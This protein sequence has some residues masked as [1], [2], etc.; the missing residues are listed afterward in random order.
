MA[1]GLDWRSDGPGWPHHERSRFVAA[2]G[3]RW[4]VQH[5]PPP[6]PQAPTWLL[7]HGTGAS[8]HSWRGLAPLL[9]AHVGLVVPDLPGHGFSAPAPAGRAGIAPVA[10]ALRALMRT[11][12]VAPQLI[13]GHSAGAAIAVRMQ[14]QEADAAPAAQRLAGTH[15]AQRVVGT[16]AA[17][18]VVGI[19][20]AL[21]PLR[22]LAGL[23]FP[24]AARLL[25]ANPLVP[26]FFA[27]RAADRAVLARLLHGTGSTLD[28][29]GSALYGRLIESPAHVAGALA[30]MAQWD[31]PALARDLPRL[32]T[33]LHLLVA[34][35]DGTVPPDDAGRVRA[36][37]PTVDVQRLAG[38]GHLAHEEDPGSIAA[39]LLALG[40]APAT[41]P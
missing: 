16:H 19:N 4:H 32:R 18:R 28:A 10:A 38:L 14:L 3:Q 6:Q 25:A 27:W 2:D 35:L 11:L 1:R 9:A 13:V 7:L 34:A 41:A 33:P 40:Q 15:A 24:P 8:T 21:L 26:R 30:M 5:W 36:L 39:R 37:L 31:L 29:E 12:A 23:V 17:Q 22:G 20:A